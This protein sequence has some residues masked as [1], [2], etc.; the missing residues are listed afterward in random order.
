MRG[1]IAAKSSRSDSAGQSA[2]TSATPFC[3]SLSKAAPSV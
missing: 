3:L 1:M 2:F